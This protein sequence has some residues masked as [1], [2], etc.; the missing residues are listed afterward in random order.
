MITGITMS[1][2]LGMGPT[3]A[4]K[5]GL[6]TAGISV[7]MAAIM[8]GTLVLH[9]P[10]GRLSDRIDRRIV[11]ALVS[12]ANGIV[13]LGFICWNISTL[14]ILLMVAFLLGG[15]GQP[16]YALCVAHSNDTIATDEILSTASS[17][18]LVFSFGSSFGPYFASLIMGQIGPK[19]LFLFLGLL[20]L[21]LLL[22]TLYDIKR[23]PK[24]TQEVKHYGF[25]STYTRT[26]GVL[27]DFENK[28]MENKGMEDSKDSD[29]SQ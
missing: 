18:L 11:I 7:F 2:Y 3:F 24:G 14:E 21:F 15:F 6:N 12:L 28:D 23:H 16:L 5:I 22:F 1:A 27:L 4:Q 8:T 9:W 17:L 10:I 20:Y 25:I 26:Q 29:V 13:C 19:G